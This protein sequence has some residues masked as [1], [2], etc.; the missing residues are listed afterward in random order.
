MSDYY[1]LDGHKA[2][3]V[4]VLTW[5]KW[6][7]GNDE[8]RCVASDLIGDSRISTVFLGLNH[9]FGQ[10][11]KPILFETMVFGGPLSDEMDR[12]CTWEEAEEGHLRMV[13]L[14][15]TSTEEGKK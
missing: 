2:I 8:D 10:S 14:V 9:N 15:R 11:G 7:E 1:I 5:A 4:D 3:K 6:L 13:G 12:Y